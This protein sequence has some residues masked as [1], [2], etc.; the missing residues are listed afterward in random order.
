MSDVYLWETFDR[1][2]REALERND[3]SQANE[4]FRSAVAAAEELESHDRLVLSLRNLA[5]TMR[6]QGLSHDSYELLNR[7]IEVAT[8]KLGDQ[9][10]Q[11][12]E[13]H[14]DLS[15]ACQELGF[16]DKA[17]AHLKQ[18]LAF[19]SLHAAP[20][21]LW[22]TLLELAKLAM[23]RE[24]AHEAAHYYGRVVELKQRALGEDHPEVA[25]ALIWLSTAHHQS[26]NHEQASP[27]VESALG[28][29]ESQ[30]AGQPLYFAQSLMAASQMMEESNQHDKALAYRRRALDILSEHLTDDDPRVWDARELIANSL[31]ALG[32]LDEAAE[33]L[34]YCAAN[35][36]DMEPHRRGAVLKNLGA[37]YLS[38]GQVEKAD[39]Y[40]AQASE[41]LKQ[42]LGADHPAYLATQEERIQYLFFTKRT[43][44][45]LELALSM[46]RATEERFGPGHPNTAQAYSSTALL[47]FKAERWELSLELMRAAEK[48]W[49]SL[50][51]QPEDVL[52]NCRI[53]IA[54]CL[55]Q[56]RQ[57]DQAE[58]ALLM[59][60]EYA[61]DNLRPLISNLRNQISA[62]KS[63]SEETE[64]EQDERPTE[65]IEEE[66][67]QDNLESPEENLQ[68]STEVEPELH[69]EPGVADL[70]PQAQIEPEVVEQEPQAQV[71][72]EVVE[73]EP[74]AAEP[75]LPDP[76]DEQYSLPDLDFLT[77]S[78]D[79]PRAEERASVSE[80]L[81]E[82][83]ETEPL[84]FNPSYSMDTTED[85]YV[86][87]G[88]PAA[89][90]EALAPANNPESDEFVER[91]K[92]PRASLA[93]NQFFE[94]TVSNQAGN[95]P[96]QVRSFFVDLGLGGFRIN[97][98]KPLGQDSPIRVSL[99]AELLGEELDVTAQVVWQRALFGETYL[100]GL[101]FGDLTQAQEHLLNRKLEGER[102]NR[103]SRQHYRLYRPFPI[104]LSAGTGEGWLS[105]YATDLSLD[106]LGTRL[107][108]PLESDTE[109]KVRLELD[110]ELPTVEVEARVA[111]CKEGENG[112][113]HG[114]QFA[115]MGPV[116]AKTIKRYIDRCL[117]F[118]PD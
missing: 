103:N 113:T 98:E 21:E 1:L 112:V 39:G 30:F 106:G 76:L 79:L 15:S 20:E 77:P 27:M 73:Q 25:Q 78:A 45:A 32:N 33:M 35:R 49:L 94:L 34:E 75:E 88:Q 11:T 66:K 9:H 3:F 58:A 51:P 92:S 19:E 44:E 63:A 90:H 108:A 46:V 54:N 82:E 91:R 107:R 55:L 97:S 28:I 83:A 7:T 89:E 29:M 52:A 17:D 74:E 102:G 37:I 104:K 47:A 117:E 105:S 65:K 100:Q 69:I 110:F 6:A 4:A 53:N 96:E 114:L 87:P 68:P 71:E 59:A 26:G 111:W 41:L 57:P 56:L 14:R 18:V 86:E 24:K 115:S 72:P 64:M 118:S 40:Y 93:L 81:M 10:S 85:E 5:A 2:G 101:E 12:I 61:Q 62:Q 70:D 8:E 116:E 31:A 42:S 22:P 84:D 109:V 50:R 43:E 60:E 13:S 48:I 99:P 95:D 16:L 23:T 67:V 38:Q 36:T 80:P